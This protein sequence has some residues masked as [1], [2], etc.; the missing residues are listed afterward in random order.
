MVK[1][2]KPAGITAAFNLNLLHRMNTELGAD[3]DLNAFKHWETYNPMTGAT[4]SY[5]VSTR[6]QTVYLSALNTPIHFE[7]WE[8]IDVEL[9]QKYSVREVEELARQT[10]FQVQ[11]HFFDGRRY[12]LDTLWQA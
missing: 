7:A 3:F 4:R 6:D 10:G 8:A 2:K 11:Q 1:R 9:S 5:I 12:F